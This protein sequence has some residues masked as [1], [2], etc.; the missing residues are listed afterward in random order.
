MGKNNKYNILDVIGNSKYHSCVIL[1]YSFDPIY[2]DRVIYPALKKKGI[3]NIIVFVDSSVLTRAL[4][5][6]VSYDFMKSEG[7]TTS[8][9]KSAGAF[10]PKII[11]LFGEK[12]GLLSIGSGNPTYSG[13][14]SNLETWLSFY[15]KDEESQ[16]LY[17]FN[18][19]W[20]YI[21]RISEFSIGL[22]SQKFQWIQE[23]CSLVNIP[24]S[25]IINGSSIEVLDNY[26][27]TIYQ[28]VLNYL[29]NEKVTRI[30]IISPFFDSKLK[31]INKLIDDYQPESIHVFVQPE[32]TSMDKN[33]IANLP[34]MVIFH[35]FYKS[36]NENT[37]YSHS[38]IIEFISTQKT[39][40]LLGSGNLSVAALGTKIEKSHNEEI[41]VFK[42][43]K[44]NY[45]VLNELNII[46]EVSTIINKDDLFSR[47]KE[48]N[49]YFEH[50]E[51]NTIYY[52][53][54]IDQTRKG[55]NIYVDK[56]PSYDIKFISHDLSN[57]IISEYEI[58]KFEKL[59]NI[60]R[61]EVP[62]K[63]RKIEYSIGYFINSNNEE[64]ISNRAVIHNV[65]LQLK[66]NP[67]PMHR[68]LQATL[69]GIEMGDSNLWDMFKLLDPDK[70]QRESY[71]PKGLHKFETSVQDK[72]SYEDD[73]KILSYDDF[74]ALET[75]I[76]D[77]SHEYFIHKATLSNIMQ[78][79]QGI[80]GL[81]EKLKEESSYSTE[82]DSEESLDQFSKG[83]EIE[84]LTN[85]VESYTLSSFKQ[86]QKHAIRY[87]KKYN[88]V[89]TKFYNEKYNGNE[90]RFALQ[91]I[92]SYLLVHYTLQPIQIEN[93]KQKEYL[94]NLFDKTDDNFISIGLRLVG[95]FYNRAIRKSVY[96][97]DIVENDYLLG[98]SIE[99][100]A[101]N[102]MIITV[103]I[104]YSLKN[105]VESPLCD[106]NTCKILYNNIID[107]TNLNTISLEY[108]RVVKYIERLFKVLQVDLITLEEF[109]HEFNF[110][111]NYY[112]NHRKDTR[113]RT[114][115]EIDADAIVFSNY[116]GYTQIR[117]IDSKKCFLREPG[118]IW[119][120]DANDFITKKKF[121]IEAA[122]L[123]LVETQ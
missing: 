93:S 92:S 25:E 107:I 96:S 106:Y 7:Y 10:H 39:Y 54:E 69:A 108:E 123:Y 51:G 31:V 2:F 4:G 117:N 61:I 82:I 64:I 18:K 3:S 113:I 114:S 43:E 76:Q 5:T 77:Y 103:L 52:I 78:I 23:Y 71:A 60:Y 90:L 8:P 38:K 37:N 98:N 59:N 9:I 95:C 53:S 102:S 80:L 47:L 12:E 89:L 68:K 101:I 121:Y 83:V 99:Y 104:S 87:F 73:S 57:E 86:H 48:E 40:Y 33:S 29:E 79:L 49:N 28:K 119:C 14:S 110:Y 44:S 115:N 111:W 91:A 72:N 36:Y 67:N 26:Q 32:M 116:I 42:E 105:D 70:Y 16:N 30:N 19:V 45:S 20:K 65:E 22:V 66:N 122:N 41:M 24:Q 112:L 118:C 84:D 6:V 35:D 62:L 63:D 15:I 27:T 81:T 13:Y 50:N 21:T 74:V 34:D 11:Q 120:K 55:F 17:L 94:F 75:Q 88:K 1:G 100:A 97:P 56:K 85:T 46:D 58:I 109:F